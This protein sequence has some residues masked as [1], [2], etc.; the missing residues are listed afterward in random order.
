[1]SLT[2]SLF[3]LMNMANRQAVVFWEESLR[4]TGFP[5]KCLPYLWEICQ[6]PGLSQD[7]L[8]HTLDVNKSSVTRNVGVLEADGYVERRASEVDRRVIFLY[9]TDRAYEILPRLLEAVNDWQATLT[10]G[11][12]PEEVELLSELAEHLTANLEALPDREDNL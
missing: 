5:G 2:S 4:Q 8:A 12:S 1:M 7:A 11:M 3:R 10:R 9:P 6:R